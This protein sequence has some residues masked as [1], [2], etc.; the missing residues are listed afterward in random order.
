[1][2]LYDF[3]VEILD[4]IFR[5]LDPSFF[6]DDLGRLTVSKLW[7]QFAL[8]RFLPELRIKSTRSLLA[9]ADNS[10]L[11]ARAEPLLEAADLTVDGLGRDFSHIRGSFAGIGKD[12]LIAL[13]DCVRAFSS[14]YDVIIA[15]LNRCPRLKSL[16]LRM[17][18]DS[19][20]GKSING[21]FDMMGGYC[22]A[23]HVL[24]TFAVRAGN[25]TS[26]VIDLAGGRS[27]SGT[28]TDPDDPDKTHFCMQLRRLL[29]SL[30]KFHCRMDRICPHMID[31]DHRTIGDWPLEEIIINLSLQDFAIDQYYYGFAPCRVPVD[32]RDPAHARQDPIEAAVVLREDFETWML[33]LAQGLKHARMVRTIWDAYPERCRLPF[34]IL[35]ED[36][37]NSH[38]YRLQPGDPWDAMGE[39]IDDGKEFGYSDDSEEEHQDEEEDHDDAAISE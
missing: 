20:A 5:E 37:L 2:H 31:F 32:C 15:F 23:D 34:D 21:L 7:Y 38:V 19:R 22:K 13:T 24:D 3:P 10:E 33:D 14:S 16:R 28:G 9:V 17:K 29:P 35:A 36:A 8:P 18:E 30:R 39:L 4:Q 6:Y 27:S 26:L 12:T 1:M 11:L 25:L